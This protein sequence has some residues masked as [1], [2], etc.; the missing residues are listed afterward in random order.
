ML[1]PF[2]RPP[3]LDDADAKGIH[4]LAWG[5]KA[6]QDSDSAWETSEADSTKHNISILHEL[7]IS[8]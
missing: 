7:A 5:D 3:S 2:V 4:F 6:R 1:L 8:L